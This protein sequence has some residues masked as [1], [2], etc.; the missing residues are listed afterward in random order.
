MPLGSRSNKG[1][2]ELLL[3][4]LDA[5]RQRRWRDRQ[6]LGAAPDRAADRDVADALQHFHMTHRGTCFIFRNGLVR[7]KQ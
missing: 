3:E 2:A 4:I 1:G 7:N 5:S 6:P